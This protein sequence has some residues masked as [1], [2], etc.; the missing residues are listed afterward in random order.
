MIWVTNTHILTSPKRQND[1]NPLFQ[2][3]NQW[4][5]LAYQ[6]QMYKVTAITRIQ[7]RE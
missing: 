4:M 3:L 7:K 5:E 1:K 6:L 2:T